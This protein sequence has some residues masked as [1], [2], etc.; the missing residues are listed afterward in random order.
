M[1]GAARTI[2]TIRI[3]TRVDIEGV[4]IMANLM[5]KPEAKCG[6]VLRPD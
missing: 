3:V 1:I 6:V 4:R 2:A 5:C